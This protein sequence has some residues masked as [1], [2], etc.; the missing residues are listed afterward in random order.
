MAEHIIK[1]L[2]EIAPR[3]IGF[4]VTKNDIN[5]IST[6]LEKG[7]YKRIHYLYG[8]DFLLGLKHYYIAKENHDECEKINSIF[9]E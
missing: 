1:E 5:N 3:S 6:Y 7:N 9:I 8:I 4:N 2:K